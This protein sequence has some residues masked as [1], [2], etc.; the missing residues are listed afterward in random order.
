MPHF[1]P[2]GVQYFTHI[3]KLFQDLTFDLRILDSPN[4]GYFEAQAFIFQNLEG[5]NLYKRACIYI[6][7]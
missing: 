3:K 7:E 5:V 2:L 1:V 4:L 6:Y